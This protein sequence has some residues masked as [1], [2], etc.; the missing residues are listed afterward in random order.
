MTTEDVYKTLRANIS[1]RA[2]SIGRLEAYADGTQYADRPS[3]FNDD[4]PLLDRAPCI[5][6]P[7]V[8]TAARS[9][10]DMLLGDGRAPKITSKPGEDSTVFDERFGLTE[11][12]S[13]DLDR[14]ICAI[15]TQARLVAVFKRLLRQGQISKTAIAIVGVRNGKLFT[16]TAKAKWA[17]ATYDGQRPEVVTQLEIRYPY[18]ETFQ[19]D[20]TGETLQRCMLYRRVIDATADTTF[21]PAKASENGGEPDKWTPD[22]AKTVLHGLGF[23]PVVWYPFLK[24]NGDVNDDDGCAIHEELLDEI[25]AL[26]RAR[27]MRHR[28]A[29]YCGDPQM[30]EFGVREDENP[31]PLGQDA[32]SIQAGPT[33]GGN[34]NWMVPSMRAGNKVG[35]QRGAG[36][37]NTY[38]DPN[39]KAQWL[40]LPSDALA[41]IADDADDLAAMIADALSWVPIDAKEMSLSTNLSG[42]A[43]EWLHK[44][45]TDKCSTIRD[46][47]G[48]GCILP[49]VDML[50]RVVLATDATKLRL[51]GAA[52][53]KSLLAKFSAEVVSD[54]GRTKRAEWISPELHLAWPPYF[55]LTETDAKMVGDNVRADKQAGNILLRTAV[56]K[57][58]PFYGI[59]DVDEYV[60]ALE[61]E[62][63]KTKPPAVVASTPRP[64]DDKALGSDEKPDSEDEPQPDAN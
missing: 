26:N 18:L 39:A 34:A 23:C 61:A 38:S 4:C 32:K 8:K 3:F 21:L 6:V 35:R 59:V 45:Q 57:L 63:E 51:A 24:E 16:D 7:I 17:K 48:E 56:E 36:V 64:L 50:L 31:A 33:D 55:A 13:A 52:K 30:V 60:A 14:G 9:Y 62:A 20:K 37:I 42:R 22:P 10:V 53:L 12:K 43:L 47:F 19:D 41:P 25:D 28:A 46:D 29:I 44:K 40:T 1:A 49:V 58:A 27:S 2:T 15:E 5:V 11:A 54:D